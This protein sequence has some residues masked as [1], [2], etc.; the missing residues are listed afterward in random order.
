VQKRTLFFSFE[1]LFEYIFIAYSVDGISMLLLRYISGVSFS[2]HFVFL[3]VLII[4]S[5]CGYLCTYECVC[6][7]VNGEK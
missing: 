2:F 3:L 5:L 6:V 7:Y 4:L 1:A